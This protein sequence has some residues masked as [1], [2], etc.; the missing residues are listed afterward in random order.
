MHPTIRGESVNPSPQGFRKFFSGPDLLSVSLR[1]RVQVLQAP[2]DESLPIE[3][4]VQFE[5]VTQRPRNAAGFDGSESPVQDEGADGV[6]DEDVVL[7]CHACIVPCGEGRSSLPSG[8][9]ERFS[10]SGQFVDVGLAAGTSVLGERHPHRLSDRIGRLR[11]DDQS[12][13]ILQQVVEQVIPSR[14]DL[15]NGTGCDLFD[16]R[17]GR[18]LTDSVL[19]RDGPLDRRLPVERD[20]AD[21]GRGE[22]AA[23]EVGDHDASDVGVLHASILARKREGVKPFGDEFR[24]ILR[25][26]MTRRHWA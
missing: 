20:A 23:F 17:I 13:T 16:G 5:R 8:L 11:F 2:F 6:S 4:L 9:S 15:V 24:R 26:R 19:H 3:V 14:D 25:S 18:D 10:V 22:I 21:I 12:A 7:A 1:Y